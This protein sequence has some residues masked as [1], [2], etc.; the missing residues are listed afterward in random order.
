MELTNALYAYAGRE[1]VGLDDARYREGIETLVAMLAPFAPHLGEELWAQ[2][3][4]GD[5][6]FDHA[7]PSWD[8]GAL[9]RESVTVVLQINGKIRDQMQAPLDADRASLAEAAQRHGRIPELIA[10]R[11]VRKVVVVPNKLVNIVI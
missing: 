4:H 2:L 9:A 10:G 3:G 7:W 6:V 5:H 11:P 1:A 8:E